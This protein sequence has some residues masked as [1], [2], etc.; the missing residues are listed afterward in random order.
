MLRRS[1]LSVLLGGVAGAVM[2]HVPA[3]AQDDWPSRT[4]RL[5]APYPPGGPVDGL[6]RAIA[7]K[8]GAEL[9]QSVV[10]DNRSGA[11]G[12]IGLNYV[13]K[14]DGDGYVIG[15]GVP[16]A[17]TVLP[18]LQKV[19]YTAEDLNYV[20]LVARVPQV[21]AV[22]PEL[23][24]TSLKELIELAKSKPG[25]LNYGSTGVGTTPHLGA[26]LLI[27]ETGIQITHVPYQGAAPAVTALLGNEIQILAADVPGLLPQLVRGVKILAV[28]AEKRVASLPDV[29]TTTELGYPK[30]QVGSNYGI[31]VP[32]TT[33]DSIR[34]KLHAALVKVLADPEVQKSIALQGGAAESSTPEVY[35]QLML[36]ET[37]K[38]KDLIKSAN[39]KIN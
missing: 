28:N 2:V 4:I 27:Q 22:S 32:E 12:S 13:L 29:P 26:E 11:G 34:S 18:Q 10:V 25:T 33:P 16:G 35:R 31:I 5:V 19:P 36:D 24:V 21:I 8:L 38:W 7:P 9:G 1:F 39:I 15:F 30:I 14:A 17:I 6:A 3:Q 20:S 23:N 37:R